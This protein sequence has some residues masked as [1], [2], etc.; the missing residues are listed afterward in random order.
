MAKEIL[1]FIKLQIPAGS[2]NPAPPVGP[3]LGQKGLNIQDFCKQFNDKTKALGQLITNKDP[4]LSHSDWEKLCSDAKKRKLGQCLARY[5]G[6][7]SKL[8]S[9]P[10]CTVAMVGESYFCLI[11]T[12]VLVSV[13]TAIFSVLDGADLQHGCNP[14]WHICPRSPW[15]SKFGCMA[16]GKVFATTRCVILRIIAAGSLDTRR[17]L[18]TFQLVRN[19]III[20]RDLE[21]KW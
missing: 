11:R 15:R 17:H 2:A 3:A 20:K 14:V 12:R 5:S 16:C 13:S 6:Q 8:T 9:P 19:H 21:L 1:G 18:R 4:N 7:P 10:D